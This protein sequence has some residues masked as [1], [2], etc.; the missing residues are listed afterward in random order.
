MEEREGQ[1]TGGAPTPGILAVGTFS[2]ASLEMLAWHPP[3]LLPHLLGHCNI[4]HV[5]EHSAVLGEQPESWEPWDG[6]V[7]Q[8]GQGLDGGA[9]VSQGPGKGNPGCASGAL[10]GVSLASVET[11]LSGVPQGSRNCCFACEGAPGT[12]RNLE[13]SKQAGRRGTAFILFLP[14]LSE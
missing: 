12:A 1:G 6:S 14:Q 9:T 4:C 5:K 10:T 2:G 13:A 3:S 11:G 7:Q 8:L